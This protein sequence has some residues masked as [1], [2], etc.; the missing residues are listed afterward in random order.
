L[1]SIASLQRVNKYA[2]ARRFFAPRIWTFLNSLQ[3]AFLRKLLGRNSPGA[4]K[5][6]ALVASGCRFRDRMREE[7]LLPSE[8]PS[9]PF[10]LCNDHVDDRRRAALVGFEACNG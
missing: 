3:E 10:H 8:Q 9:L 5:I 2:S 6:S 7:R 4:R 1:R